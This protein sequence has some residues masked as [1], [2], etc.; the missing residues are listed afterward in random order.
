M[1]IKTLFP[2]PVAPAINKCGAFAMSNRT[3]PPVIFFP[4]I[5]VSKDFESTKSFEFKISEK[6]T[7]S[8]LL[9]GTSMP[10][11]D[12]PSITPVILTGFDFN[13]IVRSSESDRILPTL[14]PLAGSN[15]YIVIMGPGFIPVT[16]PLTPK[17]ISFFSINVAFPKR[18]NLS[19]F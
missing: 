5:I 10:T 7:V 16:F 19:V 11:A 4:R 18:D 3:L 2:A 12:L 9:L 6:K 15:S 13:A 8:L 1:F 17:S 14:T